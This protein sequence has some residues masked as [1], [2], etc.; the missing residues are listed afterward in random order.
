MQIGFSSYV[1]VLVSGMPSTLV[2]T[3]SLLFK[4]WFDQSEMVFFISHS[5]VF[6]DRASICVRRFGFLCTR[7]LIF[8]I[9]GDSMVFSAS[10]I[11]RVLREIN[12]TVLGR[13]WAS[14]CVI[15]KIILVEI[16]KTLFVY[17]WFWRNRFFTVF[18]FLNIICRWHVIIIAI[19]KSRKINSLK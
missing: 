7:E 8:G 3:F 12:L 1:Q 11:L 2:M 9:F 17:V 13:K 15:Y 16:A 6:I 18:F 10:L 19:G 4:E 5:Y 14:Q